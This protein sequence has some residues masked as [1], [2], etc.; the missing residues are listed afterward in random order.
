[1]A[2]FKKLAKDTAIYGV[3]SILG[4]FLNWL[5]VPLYSYVLTSSSQYGIITNLYAWSALLI[6]ILTYGMETGFFRY[7]E[8]KSSPHTEGKVYG[9]TLVC[10]GITSLIFLIAVNIFGQPIANSLGYGDHAE[11]IKL[12]GSIVA[13]D[14]FSQI[15]FA[16]LRHKNKALTFA[17]YKL[18]NILSYILLNIFFLILCPKI[19]QSHPEWI[20]WFY[21]A[22]YGVGYILI[23]NLMSTLLMFILLT[24]YIF[25]EKLQY[26]GALL[27]KIVRYSLPLLLFGIAGIMNQT[28]DKL[29][30]PVLYPGDKMETMAQ[31][32]IYGAC[33]KIAMIMMMFTYAFRFAY[34]PFLFAKV[35]SKDSKETYALAMKYYII[36]ALLIFLGMVFT[37]DIIQLLLEEKYRVGIAIIPIVL[38]TYLTQGIIYN[39][40]VW[41]KVIDKTYYGSIFSFI[42]LVVTVLL[43]IILVPHI[44]YWGSVIAAF[45]CNFV[46]LLFSFII[47]QKKYHINYPYRSIINYFILASILFVLGYYI[48]FG[49]LWINLLFR[50]ILLSVFCVYLVKKDLPLS[51]IPYLNKFVKKHIKNKEF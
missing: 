50:A 34:E 9:S 41:Y 38:L 15:P 40:S 47:G 6:I 27:K 51:E 48:N 46:I 18:V 4:R 20:D 44:S 22:D 37:L 45:I 26:D 10:V 25:G 21:K 28:I 30:F 12:L 13:I 17:S 11:Y 5:L 3:S 35:G 7:I 29:L 36:T 2:G 33:F 1:M 8:D 24:P 42:G 19:M 49:T 39:L 16:Y 43:N 32:G 31:L 23:A 14:A